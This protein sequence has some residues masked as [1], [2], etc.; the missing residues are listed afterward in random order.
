MQNE[1]VNLKEKFIEIK[2]KESI[3]SVRK[4]STGVGAI[5]DANG[6]NIKS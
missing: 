1:I 6:K 3:K 4:N 5:L 2:K